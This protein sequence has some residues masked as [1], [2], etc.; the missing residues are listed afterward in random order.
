[1][2]K[3]EQKKEHEPLGASTPQ[4]KLRPRREGLD[5]DDDEVQPVSKL[6]FFMFS[7]GVLLCLS[8]VG[9]ALLL[10]ADIYS[11][12]LATIRGH[13]M[14]L[15]IESKIYRPVKSAISGLVRRS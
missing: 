2:G 5:A 8:A 9:V 4:G 1:M 11:P 7:S 6:K 10:E 12:T 13:P 14:M 15:D 3:Q